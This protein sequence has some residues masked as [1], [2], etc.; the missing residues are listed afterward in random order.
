MIINFIVLLREYY[1]ARSKRHRSLIFILVL[2][3]ENI[4]DRK[5]E[6]VNFHL[7][8]LEKIILNKKKS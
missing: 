5:I 6:D 7:S 2:L 4:C 1:L 8:F 3:I